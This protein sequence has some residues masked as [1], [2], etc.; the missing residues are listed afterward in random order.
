[1]VSGYR[2]AHHSETGG[3]GFDTQTVI[4]IDPKATESCTNAAHAFEV[5]RFFVSIRL[6]VLERG[7][8]YKSVSWSGMGIQISFLDWDGHTNQFLGVGWAYKSVSWTGMDIQISFLEWDGHTD[9]FLGVGWA[10]RSV[11]WSGMGIQISFL[12]RDGHTS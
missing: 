1:M 5:C 2:L 11:S 8:A 10:Y 12:E 9:Q 3:P 6:E 7:W 4:G